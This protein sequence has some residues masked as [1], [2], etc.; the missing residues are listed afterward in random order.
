[1][2]LKDKKIAQDLKKRLSQEVDLIDLKIYGSRVP[3]T[4]DEYSDL[5]VYVRVNT[6]NK[7]I[8]QKIFDIAWELGFNNN[9]FIST[10][11]F[12]DDEIKNTPLRS[13]PI[14]KNIYKYGITI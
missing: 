13:S 10:L 7:N 14:L 4:N 6:I 9:I 2:K 1:M 5:D 12:S 3:E 8:K 11:I